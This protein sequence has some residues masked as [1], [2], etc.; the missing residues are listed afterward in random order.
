[1]QTLL[2]VCAWWL[3]GGQETSSCFFWDGF[4]S[5][6]DRAAVLAY[7][8][9]LGTDEEN[10]VVLCTIAWENEEFRV[11]CACRPGFLGDSCSIV[12]PA[13]PEHAETINTTKNTSL[14]EDLLQIYQ[15]KNDFSIYGKYVQ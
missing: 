6:A 13:P 11:G 9:P 10:G 4:A 14:L 3:V 12:A 1:M 7:C 8:N 5:D 2:L 15:W